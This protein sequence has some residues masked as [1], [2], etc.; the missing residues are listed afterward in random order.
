MKLVTFRANDARGPRAGALLAAG[1]QI[2]DLS[3]AYTARYHEAA[4][5]LESVLA[6]AEGGAAALDKA[7]EVARTAPTATPDA[8][9]SRSAAELLA[10]IPQPPQM[11]DFLCFEKH[12]VQAFHQAR[13]VKSKS[14]PDPEAAE[15]ATAL[16]LVSAN[17]WMTRPMNLMLC[18]KS[19]T[20]IF[21]SGPCG[22]DPA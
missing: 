10:P 1:E 6:I 18:K 15:W 22:F 9:I 14:S 8:I 17:R 16:V 13:V 20:R 3:A 12:L 4:P 19:S 5:A 7:S 21:S 11:R 2:V